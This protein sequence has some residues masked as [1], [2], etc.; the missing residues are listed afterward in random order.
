M[1]SDKLDYFISICDA[2]QHVKD[3]TIEWSPE[4]KIPFGAFPTR[5]QKVP[6]SLFPL[7]GPLGCDTPLKDDEALLFQHYVNHVAF[8]MM[9]YVDNR[10]PWRSSYPAVALYYMSR[11]QKS[12]YQALLAQAAFNLAHLDCGRER[13]L[14][15]AA[16]YYTSAM[17]ELRNNI[18][19]QQQDY[20][21]FIAS[22][23]TLMFVEVTLTCIQKPCNCQLL[24][25]LRYTAEIP[26]R[27]ERISMV[28]GSS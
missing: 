5:Q 16:K 9:P 15:L 3:F 13:M 24:T 4:S 20:G 10:N 14:N 6:L 23:L 21:T 22:I 1:K 11:N 8:M 27:G 25:P 18:I 26:N 28:L 19:E 17:E 12:L 2:A 7:T